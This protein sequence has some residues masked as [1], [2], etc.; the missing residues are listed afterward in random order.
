MKKYSTI[1]VRGETGSK[2]VRIT[3]DDKPKIIDAVIGKWQALIDNAAELANVP[4]A[5]IM[6]LNEKTIEVFL[7]SNTKGNPYEKGEETKLFYGLYCETVIGTQEKLLIP[8]AVKNKIWKDN[9]PDVELNMISYLGFPVNWPDGEVFGTVCLLDNKENKYNERFIKLV[10]QL[11]Q[12]IETDLQLLVANNELNQKNKELEQLNQTKSRF[13]SLIS[14]DIRGNIGTLDEFLKLTIENFE[15]YDSAKLKK[16]L[17]S[18]SQN[19]ASSYLTLE[20]LLN[21][22]KHD[23][24]QLEIK[25]VPVDIVEI[26]E[27]ILDYFQQAVSLKNIQVI[28]EFYAEQALIEADE[29]MIMVALRNII[30]NAVKYNKNGGKLIIRIYRKNQKH[31]IEIEDTGIGMD[32]TTIGNLFSFY[33]SNNKSSAGQSSAGIGLMISKEFLDKHGANV[34][35]ESTPQKGSR[36]SI[37]LK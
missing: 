21:W 9:N 13:L 22:S 7:K 6:R 4:S 20:N 26:V 28:K 37:T 19:A 31:V 16:I 32:K 29:N 34:D 27:N 10:H 11:K 2:S 3:T 18:L 33:R 30:S 1:N 24:M 23:L 36:F 14:H 12:H 15:S 17:E 35:V 5:L 25:F 8:N